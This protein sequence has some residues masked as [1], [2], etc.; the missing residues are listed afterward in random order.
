MSLQLSDADWSA[1]FRSELDDRPAPPVGEACS[2]GG[3]YYSHI[4]RIPQ[5]AEGDSG[6]NIWYKAYHLKRDADL[7]LQWVKCGLPSPE[8]WR[9]YLRRCGGCDEWVSNPW[10][11]VCQACWD[12]IRPYPSWSYVVELEMASGLPG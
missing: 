11:P 6:E 9:L 3:K 4:Y 12:E 1:A 7:T 10:V 5:Y 2:H 8:H